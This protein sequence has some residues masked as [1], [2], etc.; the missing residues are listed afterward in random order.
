[1][2]QLKYKHK[3]GHGDA[4]ESEEYDASFFKDP[5][6]IKTLRKE[7]ERRIKSLL[8]DVQP[9]ESGSPTSQVEGEGEISGDLS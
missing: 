4:K 1:M 9:I 8:Q 7:C 3:K 2:T 6:L 5:R